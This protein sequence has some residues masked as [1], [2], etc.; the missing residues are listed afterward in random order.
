M[1][2]GSVRQLGFNCPNVS[3]PT[4]PLGAEVVQF[5][6]WFQVAGSLPP[7]REKPGSPDADGAHTRTTSANTPPRTPTLPARR[8]HRSMQPPNP[9]AARHSNPFTSPRARSR[10][11]IMLPRGTVLA[12]SG[13][14]GGNRTSCRRLLHDL[15]TTAAVCS[16]RPDPG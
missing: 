7:P 5:P 3:V 9:I 2:V 14:C 10:Q 15:N 12:A 8:T 4:V 6:S 16:A 1:Y 13:A 11:L